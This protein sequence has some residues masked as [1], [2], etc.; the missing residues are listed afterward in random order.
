MTEGGA[1]PVARRPAPTLHSRASAGAAIQVGSPLNNPEQIRTNLNIAERP[2]QIGRPPG[3][4]LDSRKKTNL[5]TEH[6]R[7]CARRSTPHLTSPLKGG[8]DELGKGCWGEVG[9]CLRRNDGWGRRND[10]GGGV[11]AW[12]L[13]MR[14]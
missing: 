8:R 10:G 11:R 4:P 12:A 13:A 6:R 9:S 3:S 5:N 14:G 7:S 2:D 1:A